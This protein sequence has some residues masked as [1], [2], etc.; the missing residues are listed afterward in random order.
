MA[1][2]CRA[3]SL[4]LCS[5]APTATPPASSPRPCPWGAAAAAGGRWPFSTP[6]D[7]RRRA[8]PARLTKPRQAPTGKDQTMKTKKPR[9]IGM[10][11]ASAFALLGFAALSFSA[12]A[13]ESRAPP[14]PPELEAPRYKTATNND[15]VAD[16]R[17][18]H[19]S[20]LAPTRYHTTS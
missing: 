2:L 8:W 12:T 6:P 3:P 7:G 10:A 4:P 9:G 1:A 11:R 13:A 14:L 16:V 15:P 18:G 5:A 20:T 17:D 19:L